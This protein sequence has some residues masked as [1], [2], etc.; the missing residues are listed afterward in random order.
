VLAAARCLRSEVSRYDRADMA[1]SQAMAA[2]RAGN[3]IKGP[4]RARSMRLPAGAAR[5]A[6]QDCAPV[7]HDD[8]ETSGKAR[9]AVQVSIWAG[10]AALPAEAPIRGGEDRAFVARDHAD[11][12]AGTADGV[13]VDS[14]P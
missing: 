14:A 11:A 4:C 12:G 13:Q 10:E 5:G 8:A 7:P 9:G 6:A 2:I 3:A 1:G